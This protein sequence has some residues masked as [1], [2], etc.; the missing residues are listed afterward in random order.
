MVQKNNGNV[1]IAN[2]IALIGLA[3]IGVATFFGMLFHSLDGKPAGAI[4]GAVA[5]VAGLSFLLFMSIKAKRA[6]DNPDKW[7]YVEWTCLIVYIIV[8]LLFASPFQRFFYILEEKEAM[9][10]QASQEI[11]AIKRL[12]QEYD[13]QQNKF[14]NEAVEQMQNYDASGQQ[15]KINNDLAEYINGVGRD[16]Q[17]W[18]E[19]ASAI[20]K[21]TPDVQLGDIEKKI[22]EWNILQ[23][24]SIASELETKE[25]VV[26]TQIEHKIKKFEEQNKLIPIIVGGG[27]QPYQLAGY[28]KFKLGNQPEAK[29][30]QMLRN[31]EGGTVLG[32]VIYIVLNL[33]VLLNYAVAQRTSFVGP[34]KR[35][36]PSGGLDL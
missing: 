26:W 21:L 29:F 11:D 17:G 24:S 23:L 1:S 20:V 25:S 13:H 18:K 35:K 15:K 5:L 9:Q 28:A 16:I 10:E 6:E 7:C 14:L 22:A 33:F 4:L 3:G 30:A 34:T 27:G 12:Y 36:N 2:I 8:A 32:W 19:K 31:P